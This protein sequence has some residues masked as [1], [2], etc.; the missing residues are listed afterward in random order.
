MGLLW[1]WIISESAE[2]RKSEKFNLRRNRMENMKITN[3]EKWS[4]VK[5]GFTQKTYWKHEIGKL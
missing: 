5:F 3:G 2:I 1:K 4:F